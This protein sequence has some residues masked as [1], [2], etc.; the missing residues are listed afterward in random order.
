[1]PSPDLRLATLRRGRLDVWT[2]AIRCY[3]ILDRGTDRN[4]EDARRAANDLRIL[5]GEGAL[6]MTGGWHVVAK[7]EAYR[8]ACML[9]S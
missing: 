1:M 8:I 5:I 9:Q 2:A 6:A 7:G 3:P 4:G